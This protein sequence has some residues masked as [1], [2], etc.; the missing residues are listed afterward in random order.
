MSDPNF[1]WPIHIKH[2]A[3]NTTWTKSYYANEGPNGEERVC[4]MSSIG[5][6]IVVTQVELNKDFIVLIP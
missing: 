3:T 6:T 2:N 4:Y 5:C 1:V